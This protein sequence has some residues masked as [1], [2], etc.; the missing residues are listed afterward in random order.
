LKL[1]PVVRNGEIDRD[2]LLQHGIL[3]PEQKFA[4]GIPMVHVKGLGPEFFDLDK[5]CYSSSG[6]AEITSPGRARQEQARQDQ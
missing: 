1:E 4:N 6:V 2:R 3:V 5:H